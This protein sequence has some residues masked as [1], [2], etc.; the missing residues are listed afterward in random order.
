MGNARIRQN[1]AVGVLTILSIFLCSS[2]LHHTAGLSLFSLLYICYYHINSMTNDIN[3]QI[4]Y[5]SAG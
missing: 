4:L 3:L 1:K 5:S 2:S